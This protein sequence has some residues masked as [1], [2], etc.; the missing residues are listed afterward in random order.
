MT[1]EP[2]NPTVLEIVKSKTKRFTCPFCDKQMCE[3]MAFCCDLLQYEFN[4]AKEW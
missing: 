2:P 1:F 4:K 3:G